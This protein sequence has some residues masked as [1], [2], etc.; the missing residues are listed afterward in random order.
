MSHETIAVRTHLTPTE[1]IDAIWHAHNDVIG[2]P[3]PV[4]LLE[5]LSAQSAL[6]TGRW[7]SMW[8][9][10]MG[11]LRGTGDGGEWMRIHGADEIIDGKR[12]TGAE[13]EAGFAA[14]RER[15]SGARAFVR[16]LGTATKPPNPN[17]YAAAWSAAT[18]GDVDAYCRELKAQGYFTADLGLYTNGV[19]GTVE[20][21]RSGP[22]PEFLRF[23]APAPKDEP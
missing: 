23:L 5:I 19:R 6:E 16:F 14:Y 8:C 2:G 13:V 18:A 17:R 1:A 21:L 22:M 15:Y 4:P 12:V 20:W 10:N 7:K 3:C 11:N 9:F